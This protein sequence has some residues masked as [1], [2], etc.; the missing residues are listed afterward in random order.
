MVR[1]LSFCPYL[2]AAFFIVLE[3]TTGQSSAAD[4]KV[5]VFAAA[6]LNTALEDINAQWAARTGNRAKISY[7]ASSALAKQIENGAPADIFISADLAWMDYLADR[8][9]IEPATRSNLVGNDLVLVAPKGSGLHLTIEPGFPL[10]SLLG[11]GRL[12]MANTDAVPAGKYGK[13][14]LQTLG[15]WDQ[16]KGRVAQA[17]NVRAA[18]VM[19]SRGETP[20]G[21]VYKSDA[22]SDPSVE[23]VGTFPSSTHPA[24]V[25]PVSLI[26][27][28]A[29]P[30]ARSFLEE[31]RSAQARAIFEKQG[32]TPF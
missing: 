17:E 1:R 32:F 5:L 8:R 14:A 23:T 4:G 29:S 31:L 3:A 28:T 19:V 11:G 12:S 15:V 2:I 6:S 27:S 22:I 18:L 26:G 7:A 24:I 9:L 20:I 21:V 16:V 25:Y 10:A 30:E 13:A